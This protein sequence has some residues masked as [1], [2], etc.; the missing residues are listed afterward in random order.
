MCCKATDHGVIDVCPLCGVTVKR[1]PSSDQC[2]RIKPSELMTRFDHDTTNI[3]N[4][5]FRAYQ[6]V[7]PDGTLY[8]MICSICGREIRLR[9]ESSNSGSSFYITTIFTHV[10][11][12]HWGFETSGTE[13]TL[14][15]SATV[16]NINGR[17][18]ASILRWDSS[19]L[20]FHLCLL[21]LD[22]EE[23]KR[24]VI[25]KCILTYDFVKNSDNEGAISVV[26]HSAD[27]PEK[28]LIDHLT[29]CIFC[30]MHYDSPP[31]MEI[32]LSHIFGRE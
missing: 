21:T 30:G 17:I 27:R 6:C 20:L 15:T 14:Y 32:V 10:S 19:N 29:K 9:M 3:I 5:L 11:E 16:P 12:H 7:H 18:Y 28:T 4:I 22:S 24:F 13:S 2:T 26:N 31:N 8:V 1:E 25:D 23:S